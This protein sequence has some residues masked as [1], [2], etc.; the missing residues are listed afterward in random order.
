MKSTGHTK[1]SIQGGVNFLYLRGKNRLA[2][3]ASL[4]FHLESARG[5]ED[6]L[7]CII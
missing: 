4:L 3:N 1:D 7:Q 2:Q 5:K 6:D